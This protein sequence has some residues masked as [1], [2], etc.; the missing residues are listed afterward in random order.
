M[1]YNFL[2]TG[3]KGYIGSHACKKL[4]SLGHEVFGLDLKD[5]MDIQDVNRYPKGYNIDYI[6]HFAAEPSVQKSVLNP[7]KT[8]NNNAYGTS[9]LLEWASKNNVKR[10]VFSSSA[11]VIGNGAGPESPYGLQ[12]HV[13][14][15]ECRLYSKLYGLDTVCL[16]YSNVYSADQ[17]FGGS[18]STAICTWKHLLANHKPLRIDG[19]GSQ[20]RDFIHVKDVVS[21][22]I[23]F[24]LH[25]S[26]FEGMPIEVGTG[27]KTSLNDIKKVIDMNYTV[28]WLEAPSRLGDI[29]DSCADISLA[30]EFGWKSSIIP[31]EGI[32]Q[33]FGD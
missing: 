6:L 22:N 21:A 13:S 27:T 11:A 25:K 17:P 10:V 9:V 16:R 20:T 23:H 14:E 12:K 1:K 29:Q 2:V 19:D 5:G 15:Q 26:R 4:E 32:S 3:H 24:A 18:Y 33:I 31:I 28:A 8:F 30:A 7:A